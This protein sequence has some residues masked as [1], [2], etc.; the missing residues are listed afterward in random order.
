MSTQR[1]ESSRIHP[2]KFTL[3]VAMASII[4]M[5][6]GFTSAY[7]VKM[8][9]GSFLKFKLPGIFWLSTFVIIL[10][11]FTLHLAGKSFKA[12]EM[13]RYRQLITIT[14]ILGLV[15]IICQYV[16]FSG[17]ESQG[18]ALTGKKSNSAASY[19]LVIT[20]MHML[21]VLGGVVAIAVILFQAYSAKQKNYS[22]LPIELTAIYWHFVDVLWIYLFIFYHFVG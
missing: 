22:P 11:S 17:L 20:G 16:G 7:I 2:Q 6:A 12:R 13:L 18:I 10:S 4:M 19:L 8:N 21:H 14:A 15:F 5:F 9:E 1:T 3:W